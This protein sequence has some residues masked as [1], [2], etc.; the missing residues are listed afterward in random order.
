MLILW[1]LFLTSHNGKWISLHNRINC[2]SFESSPIHAVK[3]LTFCQICRKKGQQFSV[4]STIP[5]HIPGHSQANLKQ[6]FCLISWFYVETFQ[7]SRCFYLLKIQYLLVTAEF[8][9]QTG[10]QN[11]RMHLI[12]LLQSLMQI[13]A[14][15]TSGRLLEFTKQSFKGVWQ[16]SW[17]KCSFYLFKQF[18]S[19]KM[20]NYST[21]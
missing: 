19:L 14:P 16:M 12:Q 10:L 3:I 15:G 13:V 6:N 11:S 7:K 5:G 20:P 18:L 8:R 1:A 21:Q 9:D 2:K 4:L 17:F